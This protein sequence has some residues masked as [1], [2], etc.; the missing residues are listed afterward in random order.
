VTTRAVLSDWGATLTPWHDLDLGYQTIRRIFRPVL[1]KPERHGYDLGNRSDRAA[2]GFTGGL[3][4]EG[5]KDADLRGLLSVI[6]ACRSAEAAEGLPPVALERARALVPCDSIS[7]LEL[8]SAR[9]RCYLSQ[10][11]G[12]R[13]DAQG[14]PDEDPGSDYQAFWHH[15][16]HCA[17]CCYPD[18]AHDLLSITTISD[19]YSRRQYHNTG[20]YADNFAA[21]GIEKSAMVRLSAPAGISRRLIFFRGPGPDFDGRDRL[22]LALLRPHLDEAYQEL[23]RRRAA[24][25]ALTSRQSELLRLLASGHS[26]AEIAREMVVSAHTVRKHLENIFARLGVTNRTA[27]VAKAFPTPPY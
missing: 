12:G 9:Q 4:A 21:L 19:F 5:I 26:N 10:G 24:L 23:A 16:W 20:M 18:R 3:V 22:L 25:P 2:T 14:L 13:D 17:P 7:F 15:Y 11:L 1:C 8:D 27:A 6:D